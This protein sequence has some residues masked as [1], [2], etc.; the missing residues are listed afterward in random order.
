[1]VSRRHSVSHGMI[2]SEIISIFYPPS[3]ISV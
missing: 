2:L 1:M 3:I